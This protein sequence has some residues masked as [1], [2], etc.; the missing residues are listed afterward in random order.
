[1]LHHL[2]NWVNQVTFLGIGE[3]DSYIVKFRKRVL[4]RTFFIVVL[5]AMIFILEGI[6]FDNSHVT[7]VPLF[8][9]AIA[10]VLLLFN[11]YRRFKIS[12][13]ALSFLF[14]TMFLGVII[15]YGDRL[16]MD[17]TISFF[18]VLVLTLY[19][20]YRTRI[21]N[22]LYLVFLQ[23][24]SLYFTN[25]YES[26]FA[27]YV[28][29]FDSLIVLTATTLGLFILVYQFIRES[30]KFQNRQEALNLDLDKKNK[31]LR[32][33]IFE[34]ERL[35][36][37]LLEKTDDLQRAN[38][39]LESYTYITSHDLKTPVRSINSFSDLLYKKLRHFD[40]EDAKDYLGFIKSGALQMDGILNGIIENAQSNRSSLER[41]S[42]DCDEL[43]Q[44]ISRQIFSHLENI[45][46]QFT[47]A[48]LPKVRAD[49][50]MLKKVFLNLIDN[51]FK[52]NNQTQPKVEIRY[53]STDGF[54][55]FSVVDNGIGIPDQYSEAIF[56]MFKK[57]HGANDFSGSGVGLALCKKIVELHNGKIWL[58]TS[59]PSGSTF[60]FTLPTSPTIIP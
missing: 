53:R 38:D 25:N 33:I 20:D 7:I 32:D 30:K 35:N 42:V 21:V 26:P 27:E 19:D 17:Y 47:C 13:Y 37:E 29:Y 3:D 52:Y 1:M 10:I 28:D 54:H 46:G 16:R 8:F 59:R 23:I 22:I 6:F 58:D 48:V 14:P 45:N 34:K 36:Q 56:K 11:Y 15:L 51:G 57:L 5:S 50:M 18:I 12:F 49:R 4:N 44:E 43:L 60:K 24:F 55:E 31:E 2:I 40:D 41:E 9:I 39:F